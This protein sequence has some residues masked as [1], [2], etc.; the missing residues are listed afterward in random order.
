M[1][2]IYET[3]ICM[4]IDQK[5]TKDLISADYLQFHAQEL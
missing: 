1:K 4:N 5:I 3:G 2:T